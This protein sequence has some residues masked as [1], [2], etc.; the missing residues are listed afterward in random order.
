MQRRTTASTTAGGSPSEPAP[1]L[2]LRAARRAPG[3]RAA[4]GCRGARRSWR[5]WPA[6]R[7]APPPSLP[8]PPP[9]L[10]VCVQA[11]GADDGRLPRHVRQG[12]LLH[13]LRGAG[14]TGRS[15]R[16]WWRPAAGSAAEGRPQA[17]LQRGQWPTRLPARRAAAGAHRAAGGPLSDGAGA[18]R[19]AAA[20]AALLAGVPA[21]PGAAAQGGRR[22]RHKQGGVDFV[23][24]SRSV[25]SRLAV[26][27]AS[28]R[29]TSSGAAPSGT[30][31]RGCSA[32]RCP[33]CGKTYSSRP[34]RAIV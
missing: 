1:Q 23:Q 10:R 18:G 26:A 13:L 5:S 3:Q 11:G 7:P 25:P 6:G 34:C 33:S 14:G 8:R 29:W 22:G 9:Q 19:E 31:R 32:S 4:A 27:A 30:A 15:C 16:D 12:P 28:R 21:E 24:R 2:R 20:P 17:A